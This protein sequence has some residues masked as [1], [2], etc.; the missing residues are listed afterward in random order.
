MFDGEEIRTESE[1]QDAQ[2]EEP[3]AEHEH[4][5]ISRIEVSSGPADAAGEVIELEVIN[6]C[7]EDVANQGGEDNVTQPSTA[8][9][10]STLLPS[11]SSLPINST[12]VTTAASLH[13]VQLLDN[14]KIYLIF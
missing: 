8:T 3:G 13:Q 14:C 2:N 4:E 10:L 6:H 12:S 9:A 7:S 5:E 11:S 1:Q